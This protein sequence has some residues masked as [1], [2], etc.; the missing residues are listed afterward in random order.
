MNG[1]G[2]H[3]DS[4]EFGMLEEYILYAPFLGHGQ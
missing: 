4:D 1:I 3:C 2:G